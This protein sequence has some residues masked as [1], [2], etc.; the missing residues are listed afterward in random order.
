MTLVN[1]RPDHRLQGIFTIHHLKKTDGGGLSL[2]K[3]PTSFVFSGSL[4]KLD[5]ENLTLKC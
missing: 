3:L 4:Q 2:L 1:A 5:K